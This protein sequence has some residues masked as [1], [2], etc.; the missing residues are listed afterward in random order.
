MLCRRII[1]FFSFFLCL[2]FFFLLLMFLLLP[3]LSI[4]Y[5]YSSLQA[6]FWLIYFKMEALERTS[7]IFYLHRSFIF[8]SFFYVLSFL[9]FPNNS[10][11]TQRVSFFFCFNS[12]ITSRQI[13]QNV[14]EEFAKNILQLLNSRFY[15]GVCVCVCVY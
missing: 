15:L 9:K 5:A 1:F 14:L 4:F 13:C 2:S 3:Q 10:I 8:H 12:T 6:I 11:K 7:D